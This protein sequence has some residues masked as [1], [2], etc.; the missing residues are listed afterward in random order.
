VRADPGPDGGDPGQQPV[1]QRGQAAPGGGVRGRVSE[2]AGLAVARITGELA[3]LV[4]QASAEAVAVVRN[5]RRALP[6]T[7]LST[8]K[9]RS[10]VGFVEI[11]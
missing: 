4:E 6:R 2:H 1:I 8:R 5:A 9:A 10:S 3:G 7:T 11:R